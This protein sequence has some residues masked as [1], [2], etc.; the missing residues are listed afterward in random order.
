MRG[1][2]L[3]K[4]RKTSDHIFFKFFYKLMWHRRRFL[5][6]I[7]KIHITKALRNP[8]LAADK[9]VWDLSMS[10]F[11]EGG[12]QGG[13]KV[14]VLYLKVCCKISCRKLLLSFELAPLSHKII[15]GDSLLRNSSIFLKIQPQFSKLILWAAA[16]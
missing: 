5:A 14:K 11:G 1:S 6:A 10:V 3:V 7:W 9:V 8:R 4:L 16:A 15:S 13:S 12:G 2:H